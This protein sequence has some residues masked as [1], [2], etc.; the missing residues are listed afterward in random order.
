M[1]STPHPLNKKEKTMAKLDDYISG[2][3]SSVARARYSADI[4]VAEVARLYKDDDVLKCFAVPHMRIGDIEIDLPYALDSHTPVQEVLSCDT[5]LMCTRIEQAFYDSYEGVEVPFEG[6]PKVTQDI[7]TY[8]DEIS[9][10]IESLGFEYIESNSF[11][12]SLRDTVE[13]WCGH[14]TEVEIPDEMM[15]LSAVY[16]ITEAIRSAVTV[17]TTGGMQ[18]IAEAN[19]LQSYDSKAITHV[20]I[21]IHEDGMVWAGETL[22]PE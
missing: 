19:Q 10:N 3:V 1:G 16:K 20:K 15:H 11:Q 7:Q 9:P 22:I 21:K 18:V 6:S 4:Q 12:S 8:V 14:C 5:E 17:T 13:T 2:L